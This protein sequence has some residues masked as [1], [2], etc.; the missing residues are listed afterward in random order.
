MGEHVHV[1]IVYYSSSQHE[2]LVLLRRT[3]SGQLSRLLSM[4][5]QL[6]LVLGN[7]VSGAIECRWPHGMWHRIPHSLPLPPCQ[8]SVF[9]TVPILLS[10]FNAS[11]SSY[12]CCPIVKHAGYLLAGNFVTR[13]KARCTLF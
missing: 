10:T 5:I 11:S 2:T 3:V 13:C 7:T 8:I 1:L 12:L 4:T 6:M 9:F